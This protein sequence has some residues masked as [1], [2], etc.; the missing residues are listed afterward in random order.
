MKKQLLLFMACM[1]FA[2]LSFGQTKFGVGA[3]Y[4]GDFGVQARANLD[5]GDKLGVIPSFSYYFTDIGSAWSIDA[6]LTYDVAV[7]GDEMP[8]Y[9]LGGLDYTTVSFGGSSNSEIGI[10][11]GAGIEINSHIYIEPFWRKAFCDFCG[12]DIGFNAGY[13][14]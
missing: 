3:T 1:G 5:L 11:I 7:V 4:I 14:F 13:Y 12:S 8:I 9:L 10:N 2:A 6:N